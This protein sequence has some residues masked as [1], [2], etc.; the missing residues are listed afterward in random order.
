[1]DGPQGARGDPNPE[2]KERKKRM[3]AQLEQLKQELEQVKT[4][5]KT[6]KAE[7][8]AIK[9]ERHQERVNAALETR[10]KAGL[11]EAKDRQTEATRLK[12]LDDGILVLLA[13]DAG[14][15]AERMARA[16]PAGPKAKYTGDDKGTF[17]ASVESKREEL[18]GYKRDAS[19]KVVV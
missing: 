8:D 14:K 15:V 18:F 6:L 12:E 16:T 11:F 2:E 19:G 1:M 17:E 9:A 5:N 13:E 4:E 7:L 3:E 10:L